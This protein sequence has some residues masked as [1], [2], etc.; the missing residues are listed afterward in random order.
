MMILKLIQISSWLWTTCETLTCATRT[1]PASSA[2]LSW[3]VSWSTTHV[4]WKNTRMSWQHQS[5]VKVS[6]PPLSL[7]LSLSHTQKF[8]NMSSCIYLQT[9]DSGL[10]LPLNAQVTVLQVRQENA[11]FCLHSQPSISFS[12]PGQHLGT[13]WEPYTLMIPI[14]SSD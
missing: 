3:V 7:S 10:T 1:R 14:D 11:W 12:F 2:Q 8:L 4:L 9:S 6:P 13:Q 5:V